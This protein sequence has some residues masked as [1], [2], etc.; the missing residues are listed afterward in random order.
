MYKYLPIKDVYARD[1]LDSRGNP[2]IEVE[3]LAGDDSIGRA[4][5][6]SGASTG[7][8][9]AVELRDGEKRYRGLGVSHAVDHINAKIAPEITGMNVFGQAA[10]DGVLR[11]LDGTDNKSNLGANALLGVSMAAA[12]AAAI[13]LGM[14]LYA[15]LGGT[16]AKR[17]PVPMMNIMNGGRHADNTI[18]IQEFMI[19]PVG[20]C[21]FKEG[22]RM[23]AEV[24]HTLKE[25]LKDAGLSTA[26]GDEGG[27]A[28]NLP[29]ARET[30][31]I[32]VEAIEK[33]GYCPGKDISLALDAA[34]SELYDKH[35]KKYVF[36]GEAKMHGHKV[37]RSAEELIDYYE[38]L[39]EEFPIVSLEDPLDEEDWDGW[40]LLTTRSGLR[41]QLVGDDLFVTNTQRL[42]KGIE[43]EAANAI[44]VKVNQI[45]TLTEAFDA[46]EMAKNAGYRAVISHRS[47]ETVDS[48]IADIAVAFNAGQIKTGAPCRGERVE[49]YNRLLRIEDELGDAAEYTNPFNEQKRR[50]D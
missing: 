35:F 42:K 16:N 37:I 25:I 4:G 7:Q 22:L 24:Y 29:D 39:I 43:R 12:R 31:R 1:I 13:A 18:D 38:E 47:G 32:M 10:L 27:F 11:K 2:T 26:V 46:V 23:C 3:V 28:P 34:A 5:V 17:L 48:I 9:E 8:F 44:L 36:E 49:K 30:L 6:P 21:C 19:M 41:T 15:Y 50:A 14:P 20:A 33:A 45:G 40:E